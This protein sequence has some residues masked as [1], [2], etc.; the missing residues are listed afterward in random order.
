MVAHERPVFVGFQR[1]HSDSSDVSTDESEITA[2]SRSMVNSRQ[3]SRNLSRTAGKQDE[4]ADRLKRE[5]AEEGLRRS[6]WFTIART[7]RKDLGI[8]A[9]AIFFSVVR[10]LMTS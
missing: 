3:L 1:Q 7:A 6:S 2:M 8:I 10:G 4:Q 5:L 9:V